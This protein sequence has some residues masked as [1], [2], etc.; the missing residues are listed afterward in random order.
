[1]NTQKGFTLIELMIVVAI[2]GILAAIAIPAYQNY[3]RNAIDNQCLASTKNYTSQFNL[4][5][6]DP[7]DTTPAPNVDDFKTDN[8]TIAAPADV[9]SKST[10]VGTITKGNKASANCVVATGQ[11]KLI[12]KV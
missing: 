6:N 4:H 3:T 12:D 10:I 5:E 7:T 9:D 1:M 11:C 2:I 8:C